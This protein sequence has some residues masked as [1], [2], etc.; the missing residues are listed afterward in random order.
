MS[1]EQKYNGWANYATWRVHLEFF[2]G[3]D[4]H[5]IRDQISGMELHEVGYHAKETCEQFIYD[6]LPESIDSGK[7]G[8]LTPVS[9]VRGWAVAFLFDVDWREIAEAL[10]EAAG[11]K[12][13]NEN[14]NS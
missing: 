1:T 10:L 11:L 8:D 4:P 14:Q 9:M 7:R 6:S 5:D 12:E 13:N 3:M 2:D